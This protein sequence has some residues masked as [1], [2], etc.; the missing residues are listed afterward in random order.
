MSK[1]IKLDIVS[2]VVCPW[3]II[4]YKRLDAAIKELGMEDN[5][6][7]EWQPFQLNPDMPP[8]GEDLRAHLKRKYGTTLE[9]SIRFRKEMAELGEEVGFKF[10]YFDGL[11]AVNTLDAHILLEYA[12]SVGKQ[13][14]LK[15]RLFASFYSEQKDISN[16]SI[17]EQELQSVGLNV[18]DAM[19]CLDDD[20]LRNHVRAQEQQWKQTGISGVPTIVFNRESAI[21]GAQSVDTYKQVLTELAKAVVVN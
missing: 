9:D 5:I 14:E 8:E 17:L 2:D 16:K 10:D 19:A 3:C 13:T 4:G 1:K 20:I 7:I 18:D 11:K 21:S 12:K 6:K 15:N